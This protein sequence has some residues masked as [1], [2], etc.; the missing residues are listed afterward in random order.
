MCFCNTAIVFILQ[1]GVWSNQ[2]FLEDDTDYRG[3]Q[4]AC[5]W[6]SASIDE[7]QVWFWTYPKFCRKRFWLLV[8][9]ITSKLWSE[10][11]TKSWK[12][13]NK[14]WKFS[15]NNVDRLLNFLPL[16]CCVEAEARSYAAAKVHHCVCHLRWDFCRVE[17]LGEIMTWESE[18]T[19][20]SGWST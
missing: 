11:P 15:R 16:W 3:A 19:R 6:T 17:I 20:E 1:F 14:S 8:Y 2:S 5:I 4:A 18:P 13:Q 12:F 9:M 7:K 10:N